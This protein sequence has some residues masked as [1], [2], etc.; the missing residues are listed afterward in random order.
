MGS[1]CCPDLRE[2]A[3]SREAGWAD[4]RK[5]RPSGNLPFCSGDAHLSQI[6]HGMLACC[7]H[8][9]G[10]TMWAIRQE[11]G[12]LCHRFAYYILG[13]RYGK[14]GGLCLRKIC[15]AFSWRNS[16]RWKKTGCAGDEFIAIPRYWPNRKPR[17]KMQ[18][19]S[20]HADLPLWV[21]GTSRCALE[22]RTEYV[23][24][25]PFAFPVPFPLR[26]IPN[27]SKLGL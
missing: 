12:V 18:A 1:H 19:Y 8:K 6:L 3:V 5:V 27:L 17:R 7:S 25:S 22:E 21:I 23:S 9:H 2:D 15:T 13:N 10:S 26:V 11:C 4:S 16:M 14:I 20:Q 24:F